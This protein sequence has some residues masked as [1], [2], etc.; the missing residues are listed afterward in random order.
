[1]REAETRRTSLRQ[2]LTGRRANAFI[3]D[4][5]TTYVQHQQT[6]GLSNGTIDR[7]LSLLGAAYK[8]RLE[9]GKLVRRPVIHLLKEARPRQGF[10]EESQSLAVR[11]HLADDL[12]VAVTLMWQYGWR[13]SE[14]MALQQNQIDLEAGT[15][16]LESGSTKNGERRIV[17]M[18]PELTALVTVPI[19]QGK[20]M[21][22]RIGRVLP[23]LFVLLHGC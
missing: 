14:V 5:L 13:R 9:H 1:M 4:V 2:F 10:F 6:G 21:S 11:K 20:V 8:L 23:Q 15:L 19:G 12:Q 3:G 22:R 16:S 18:V 17:Y 7:E